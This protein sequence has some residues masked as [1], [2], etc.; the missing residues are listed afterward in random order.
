MAQEQ[1]PPAFQCET[2]D[3]FL[4]DQDLY[5]DDHE[6]FTTTESELEENVRNYGEAVIGDLLGAL[7]GI[8]LGNASAA[9]YTA[10]L[11]LDC[12]LVKEDPA[13][14]SSDIFGS[15]ENLSS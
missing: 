11:A 15:L 2:L 6:L 1:D 14:S 9:E 4:S 3:G 10:G 8:E 7:P 13:F 5:E 12:G